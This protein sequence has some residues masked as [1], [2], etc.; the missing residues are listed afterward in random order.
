MQFLE[1]WRFCN[2]GFESKKDSL[3]PDCFFL[4]E[5]NV[6]TCHKQNEKPHRTQRPVAGASFLNIDLRVVPFATTVLAS[7]NLP[8]VL[9]PSQILTCEH[10]Q[11][12][13]SQVNFNLG[14]LASRLTNW[15]QRL[16][17]R[18][19]LSHFSHHAATYI[20]TSTL[21]AYLAPKHNLSALR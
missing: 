14:V 11:L 5:S 6:L 1:E 18:A 9:E 4:W 12:H 8:R 3:C 10:W 7:E 21:T 19:V 13:P 15:P 2:K 20:L 16:T 17:R